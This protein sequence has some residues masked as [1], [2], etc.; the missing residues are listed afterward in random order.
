MKSSRMIETITRTVVLVSVLWLCLGFSA[1]AQ[2]F[3]L[4]DI[5]SDNMVL[6]QNSSITIWGWGDPSAR[7]RVITSWDEDTLKTMANSFAKWQVVL[8]SPAAGGPY[9]ITVTGEGRT[10]VIHNVMIGE[11][12]LCTGQS[13]MEF[14][15]SWRTMKDWKTDTAGA[16]FPEIR[17]FHIARTTA[18]YPEA[19][20]RGSWEICTPSTMFEFSAAGYFFG[21]SLY[22]HLQVPIGLIET[23]WGGSPVETWMPDS[24]FK[25]DP[26]LAKSAAVLKPVPWCPMVE[27]VCFNA[28]VAPLVNYPVAGAIWY[29]GETNVA[30]PGTY[31]RAFSK[32]I[33]CWRNLWQKQFAF[34]FVQIAPFHYDS[35]DS[36]ALVR[37]AQLQTYRDVP[38]T[39]IVVT[40]DISADTNNIHP[41]D[42]LD[43]GERLAN[44]ALANTYHQDGIV[45]SGPLYKGMRVDKDRVSVFF[46][47]ANSGL[48]IKGD[49]LKD[50]WIAGKNRQFYPARAEIQDS[51]LEVYAPEVPH[52]VAVRFGFSNTAMPNLFNQDGLPA[53]PFR[54]DDW[55]VE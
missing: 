36:A 2:Q 10:L 46:D 4:P 18:D 13:N 43:V 21:R 52:P 29:Q 20:V 47:F 35:K 15:A 1:S 6:Q 9:T 22:Q 38:N 48:K 7:V 11:N 14:S 55:P 50:I 41:T 45:F 54:T 34:Y 17:F 8:N 12:W 24:I 42:K 16:D 3:R 39:G 30:N 31:E 27:A 33:S 26:V 25:S 23:C 40:T 5:Y 19:E 49:T 51:V 32:M 37:E 28:M 44:W 53:S